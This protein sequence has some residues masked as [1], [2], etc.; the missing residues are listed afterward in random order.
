MNEKKNC[1][2][3]EVDHTGLDK[4]E[5]QIDRIVEKLKE[6]DSLVDELA[7]K[8]NGDRLAALEKPILDSADGIVLNGIDISKLPIKSCISTNDDI[9]GFRTITVVLKWIVK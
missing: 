2:E 8:T 1:I 7:S 4:C 6:A 5:E 9:T 3:I